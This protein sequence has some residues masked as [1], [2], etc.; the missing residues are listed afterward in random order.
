MVV[1]T[2]RVSHGIVR[3]KS[4]IRRHLQDRRV[5]R[6]EGLKSSGPDFG[7]DTFHR[8][9]VPERRPLR[10]QLPAFFAPPCLVI[11][12]FAG[13]ARTEAP[14][15]R[16]EQA[17]GETCAAHGAPKELCFLCDASLREKGRLWCSEHGRYEDRCWLCHPELR[18]ATRAYCDKHGLY[19]DECFLCHPELK[20]TTAE[21][22][23]AAELMCEE[24][25][26]PEG[27]CGICHPELLAGK[28]PGEGMKVR[29]PSSASAAKA[30][31][32]VAAAGAGGLQDG[33]DC[34]AEIVFDQTSVAEVSSLVRGTL[35][36]VEVD[37][38]DRVHK[39][40]L[41]ARIASAETGEAQSEYLKALADES[42]HGKTLE[43]ARRLRE[44]GVISD[45][46]LQIAE[47]A[48]KSASAAAREARQH[49][50][51]LGF[52]K[53]QIEA[54]ASGAEAPA[55]LELR[56][57]FSGEIVDRTAV[58]GM[59]VETGKPLFTVADTAKVWAMVDLP[60]SQLS[61][62]HVG[63][64]VRL[65]VESLPGRTFTGRLTWLSA[66]VDERTRMAQGRVELSNAEGLLKARMFARA[67]ILTHA[68]DRTVVVPR[69]AVQSVGDATVV[70][71]READDLFE[72]RP[73][74]LGVARAGE[75]EVVAGL[76]AA[77]PLV[78]AGA[79]TLKSQLLISR[80]GAGCAD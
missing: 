58:R 56:A 13:C 9:N 22:A 18:D 12:A 61:R 19:E 24:H 28:R 72:V 10:L 76:R 16:V 36:S 43:R 15:P 59:L 44:E 51:V 21:A 62:A 40:E 25:G 75:V 5:T 65:T 60:E 45:Q 3:A 35:R 38:G 48:S 11:A 34:F 49:L 73:V 53:A 69:A 79:F 80:L 29:L 71:V 27:E 67:T 66:S 33:I 77:E 54:L 1:Q 41:L 4:W 14:A 47:A 17:K 52:S 32:E 46:D 30:G 26:V 63:Q 20:K 70:F 37:L 23:P 42:L 55:E 74:R 68:P 6:F 2:M 7:N 57:P 78:V 8:G 64:E 50:A 31:I 39:G